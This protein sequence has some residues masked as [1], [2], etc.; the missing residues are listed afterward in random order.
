MKNF[1]IF[2]CILSGFNLSAHNTGGIAGK[3]TDA[4]TGKPLPFVSISIK[5]TIIGV[6]SDL[7]GVYSFKNLYIGTY[8]LTAYHLGY[9]VES[10]E[11]EV[12]ENSVETIDI[13]LQPVSIE[14]KDVLI[15]TVKPISAASSREV[16]NIDLMILQN[17]ST[18][19][20]LQRVPGLVI[21]QHQGGGKA[22][23]ILIRGFDCDHGTDINLSVDN[24]P[25]NMVTHAHGQGYADLH[26]VIP[27]VI[28]EFNVY[29]G[30]YFAEF[31]D[32]STG[33]S[34]TFK[35]RDVLENNLLKLEAGQFNTYKATMLLQTKE[36]GNQ[37][38]VYFGGQYYRTD[39]P[40]K[41]PQDFQRMNLFGKYFTSLTDRSKLSLS[42]S[43]FTCAWDASGQIP[44]RAV[45]NGIIDRFGA[46]DDLEGGVTG[47]QNV[48]IEYSYK[49]NNNDNFIIQN[50]FSKYNFKLFSNFTLFAQDSVRGD[51]IE[52]LENRNLF[53]MNA[54][55]NFTRE[56]NERIFKTTVGGGFRADDID[57]ALWHS[58]DKERFENF[59]D[60]GV[61][62]RNYYLWVQEEIILSPKLR[63]NLG[64]REDYFT[65]NVNDRTIL[66]SNSTPLPHASGFEQQNIVSPKVNITFT[67][68]KNFDIFLNSGLGFHSNDARNIIIGSRIRELRKLYNNQGLTTEQGDS[69][70]AMAN[71]EKEQENTTTLPRA[72]GAEIGFRIKIKDRLHIGMDFWYLH[73]E[74]EFVYVGDGGTT[75]LSDPTQRFGFDF[76]LRWKITNWLWLNNDFCLSRAELIGLPKGENYV[77]LSPQIVSTGGLNMT[78]FKNFT[79]NLM[80]RYVSD[81]PGNE[82]FS[83]V[84]PGH[85][86]FNAGISYE[87]KHF[88]FSGTIENILNTEWNEA[89]FDTETRLKGEPAPITEIC[90]TPGNPRNFQFGVSYK[91]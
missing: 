44:E 89:Q 35:T 12:K 29:K 68:V 66:D 80:Y 7:N 3:I 25:V 32:F 8:T 1:L 20:M 58:P 4:T 48:N 56:Y 79:A 50:Y 2:L 27:E 39:G 36:G 16:R 70:L 45:K 23:Q 69:L 62:Q 57:V 6:S 31:G 85:L 28:E 76:D 41:S 33:A 77:P 51:M 87:Y 52:Q 46:L 11:V 47:R 88:I 40:F 83:N 13:A 84:A 71:F 60:C 78:K 10:R 17:R 73:L 54:R 63:F 75:E 67:P 74:K 38:N 15:A 64:L 9:Q 53:G 14:L 82:D 5:G 22:E 34:V 21:T 30:P 65:F 49:G 18:Q 81:R 91:F 90:F 86:I 55:Y 43:S 19:D 37:Q 61:A 26:F 24:I 42:L 59:T 72:T